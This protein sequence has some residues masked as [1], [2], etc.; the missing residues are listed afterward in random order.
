[1]SIISAADKAVR[2]ILS[3][4]CIVRAGRTMRLFFL[5]PLRVLLLC[6][7][8]G[9]CATHPLFAQEDE[10]DD[11]VGR[12][13]HLDTI[14]LTSGRKLVVKV[15]SVTSHGVYYTKPNEEEELSFERRNVYRVTYSTGQTETM[16]EKALETLDALD[17]RAV[18]LYEN[19]D[20]VNGLY[21]HGMIFAE[22]GKGSKS[23]RNAQR[24]AE[25][26][27]QKRASQKKAIAVLIHKRSTSGGYGEVPTYR[28]DGEAFGTE[29]LE[30]GFVDEGEAAERRKASKGKNRRRKKK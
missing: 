22:S 15:V 25:A 8:G 29:P 18:I 6:V 20:D 26:K 17:W 11:E 12:L 5:F 14:V 3:A 1:M 30:E 21:S 9:L 23:L 10:E 4:R 28:I 7:V 16:T 27:L 19:P 13:Q 24:S 2:I